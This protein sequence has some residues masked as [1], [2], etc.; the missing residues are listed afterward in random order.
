MFLS[1]FTINNKMMKYFTIFPIL[2]FLMAC[3][4][5]RQMPCQ[6][7]LAKDSRQAL[8]WQ[9]Q[10]G[11]YRA[12]CL[13]AFSLAKY[14]LGQRIAEQLA[15]GP[16]SK[17]LALVTDVDET[18]V[19]NSDY[20]VFLLRHNLPNKTAYWRDWT[21]RAE[22]TAMPGAVEF[23]HWVDQQGVRICYITNRDT[24]EMLATRKN[25]AALGFPQV[26]S[27][28]F[29][30]KVEDSNKEPRRAQVRQQYDI[31][32]FLGD[33]LGDF[34]EAGDPTIAARNEKVVAHQADFG[35]K[36]IALPNP[37]YGNFE[38]ERFYKGPPLS[39]IGQ[40]SL[41]NAALRGY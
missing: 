7:N 16:G 34:F 2:L 24:S 18:L 33:N 37:I 12:L 23:L 21:K 5:A 11:E 30:P 38:I 8:I 3:G 10:S 6:P 15:K 41:R 25:L 20:Q 1:Y 28:H 4:S 35:I 9:Q 32:L 22:A 39:P 40:D 17:P 14:Q 31:A 19:D 29:Y 27:E 13:Q 26:S 36:Y